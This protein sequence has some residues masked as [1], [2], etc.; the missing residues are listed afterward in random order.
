M[1]MNHIGKCLI[2]LMCLLLTSISCSSQPV[3]K[4]TAPTQQE[5]GAVEIEFV[6]V[7]QSAETEP[8]NNPPAL[9]KLPTV[10]HVDTIGENIVF[11]ISAGYSME[12]EPLAVQKIFFV[13]EPETEL[14]FIVRLPET[15]LP[16]LTAGA[17]QVPYRELTTTLQVRKADLPDGWEHMP[18]TL[19]DARGN[20]LE[21]PTTAEQALFVADDI[22]IWGTAPIEYDVYPLPYRNG[23]VWHIVEQGLAR[24][25]MPGADADWFEGNKSVHARAALLLSPD[26]LHLIEGLITYLDV[27]DQVLHEYPLLSG[28]PV[29]LGGHEDAPELSREASLW[30]NHLKGATLGAAKV[31][32]D[33][34][35]I[36]VS[37]GNASPPDCSPRILD[38]QV[39]A[40]G[41]EVEVDMASGGSNQL[42][43]RFLEV[44]SSGSYHPP[45]VFTV[46]L[47]TL[48]QLHNPD[49]LPPVPLDDGQAVVMHQ[50][51]PIGV[52]LDRPLLRLSGYA[53]LKNGEL[54]WQ[55]NTTDGTLIER[56]SFKAAA[57]DP[58]WGS[59]VTQSYLPWPNGAES[60]V[61]L[62]LL[63]PTM[64][65]EQHHVLKEW[66]VQVALPEDLQDWRNLMLSSVGSETQDQR[67]NRMVKIEN[68][69]SQ[70]KVLHSD[71]FFLQTDTGERLA[72]AESETFVAPP[73]SESFF[74]VEFPGT[75]D[76]ILLFAPDGT[77][78][79]QL[80]LVP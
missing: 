8:E 79:E 59:F 28:S 67:T 7:P 19:Y 6:S 16:N 4:H 27:S 51:P 72:A 74:I 33:Q 73:G 58:D 15:D 3:E 75:E 62:Q 20:R 65:R 71:Q 35:L 14:R 23:M 37:C 60:T 43:W 11:R 53:R 61:Q 68:L 70:P 50:E 1:R 52:T 9:P 31:F 17:N 34:L 24:P 76:G 45:V 18:R 5:N 77:D 66:Q 55:M 12:T 40:R 2:L 64:N 39:S 49:G 57:A 56:V 26:D 47:G 54:M 38:L 46:P 48:P 41:I 30:V 42:D 13:K 63:T 78:E 69:G 32:G 44:N 25:E 10:E 29:D 36:A 80:W 22:L 21:F